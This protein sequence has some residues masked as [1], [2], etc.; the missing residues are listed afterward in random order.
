MGGESAAP[1][2]ALGCARFGQPLGGSSVPRRASAA[3]ARRASHP[4]AHSPALAPFSAHTVSTLAILNQL[5]GSLL[6]HPMPRHPSYLRLQVLPAGWLG[7]AA[8]AKRHAPRR[9]RPAQAQAPSRARVRGPSARRTRGEAGL[10]RLEQARHRR[11]KRRQPRLG[12]VRTS[13]P[14]EPTQQR[15]LSGNGWTGLDERGSSHVRDDRGGRL[16]GVSGEACG[17]TRSGE[18]A[19]SYKASRR[20]GRTCT[21]RVRTPSPGR[22]ASTTCPPPNSTTAI[23]DPPSLQV[24]R[25]SCAAA[26]WQTADRDNS[27]PLTIRNPV[28]MPFRPPEACA[29][30]TACKLD[31]PRG[32]RPVASSR[33]DCRMAI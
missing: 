26:R 31:T 23:I 29:V 28:G 17:G 24:A 18:V 22:A 33:S 1:L 7:G 21:R 3:P 10:A 32:R 15:C 8:E 14:R 19:I 11:S 27:P 30:Q 2:R 5:V 6:S 12:R 4:P 20:F 9:P 25:A 13:A 16:E